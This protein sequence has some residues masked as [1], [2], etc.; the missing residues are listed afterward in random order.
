MIDSKYNAYTFMFGKYRD[1]FLIDVL[2][3]DPDYFNWLHTQPWTKQ[4]EKLSSF[5]EYIYSGDIKGF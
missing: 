3:K 4:Y 5:L 1:E 2:Y